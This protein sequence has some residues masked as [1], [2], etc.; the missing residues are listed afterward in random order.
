M[1]KI[2]QKPFLPLEKQILV[3][4]HKKRL[5]KIRRVAEVLNSK[6]TAKAKDSYWQGIIDH[7]HEQM[8]KAGIPDNTIDQE[9]ASF[10]NEVQKMLAYKYNNLA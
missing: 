7:L 3:F 1:A 8:K 5:S 9:L 4:P 2:I 6:P 10:S